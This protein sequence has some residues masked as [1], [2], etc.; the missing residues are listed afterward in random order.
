MNDEDIRN[1]LR[2][3]GGMD[4]YLTYIMRELEA[5]E[6]IIYKEN[7]SAANYIYWKAR[8]DAFSDMRDEYCKNR[9]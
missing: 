9:K 8:R 6:E 7:L 2:K 5:C 3:A 4:N 1:L